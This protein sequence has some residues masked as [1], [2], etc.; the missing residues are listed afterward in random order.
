VREAMSSFVVLALDRHV[1]ESYA[2]LR[3]RLFRTHSPKDAKG[4]LTAKGVPDLW[5]RTSD[6]LLGIQENDLWIAGQAMERNLM[7]LTTDRM[8]HIMQAAGPDLRSQ[9]WQ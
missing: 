5:E 4:R 2:E 6:K 8:T 9:L 7:L 1:V 3:A